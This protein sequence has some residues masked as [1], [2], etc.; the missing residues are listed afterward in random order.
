MEVVVADTIWKRLRGLIGRPEPAPGRA[1]LLAPAGSVHTCFMGYP[2]DVVFLDG[3]GLVLAVHEAVPPWRLRAQR[4]A[5]AA[6]EL[7]AG[8]ARRL[9]LERGK[10]TVCCSSS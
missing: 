6:L 3:N 8:E 5:R 10:L 1:F 7:R 4:G 2:I 9:G